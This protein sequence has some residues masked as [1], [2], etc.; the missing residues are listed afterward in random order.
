MFRFVFEK[1]NFWIKF[2]R[3][4][5]DNVINYSQ[6]GGISVVT[7]K[8][9]RTS[10]LLISRALP[11]DSGNYTCAPSTAESASVL[12]HV[13]NGEWVPRYYCQRVAMCLRVSLFARIVK[14]IHFTKSF[15]SFWTVFW[16]WRTSRKSPNT[17]RRIKLCRNERWIFV[18]KILQKQ[19][20]YLY[21]TARRVFASFIS[22]H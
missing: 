9:T 22:F 4:K 16:C 1:I 14:F 19:R 18:I 5:G 12:V 21:A 20:I 10:R 17:S 15:I 7:E 8:Q 6:R 2:Y 11:A 3:Y 13:L